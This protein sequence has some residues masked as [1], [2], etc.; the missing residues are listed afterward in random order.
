MVDASGNV[1]VTGFSA[2]IKYLEDGTG[3]WTNIWPTLGG[4]TA[5]A[6]DGHG[7]ALVTGTSHNG[8]ND[9]Y[10]TAKYAAANGALLWEKRYIGGIA[11][12]LALGPNGMV[13]VTGFSPVGSSSGDYATVVYRDDVY[14]IA[15]ALVPAGIRLRFTG[16]PG[17]SYPI[18]RAPAVTGPW[19]PINTQ[20]A[21]PTGLLE[22]LDTPL[23]AGS[24]F[25]RTVQP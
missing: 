18:E 10:Y 7:N 2:T 3:A 22:Y 11:T 24:A 5:L 12:D 21:P 15:I 6:L 19:T 17:R 1:V 13:V 23:P 4:A 14:P 9:D 8:T 20:T 16:I 25:Y